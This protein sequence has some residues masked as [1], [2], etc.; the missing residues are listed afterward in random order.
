MCDSGLDQLSKQFQDSDLIQDED[1]NNNKP[2]TILLLDING[3]RAL[4]AVNIVLSS[5]KSMFPSLRLIVVKSVEL[6]QH[7]IETY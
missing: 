7:Y 1:N 6:Y 3:N 2:P 4:D 5:M